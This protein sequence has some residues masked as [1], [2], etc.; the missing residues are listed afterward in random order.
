MNKRM[1]NDLMEMNQN[2]SIQISKYLC[3]HTNQILKS[4]KVVNE[5][6]TDWF[7]VEIYYKIFISYEYT[8][9]VGWINFVF[10]YC[11]LFSKYLIQ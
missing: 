9:I 3:L 7:F 6:I 1:G 5:M 4:L 2:N 10:T 11:F 8:R